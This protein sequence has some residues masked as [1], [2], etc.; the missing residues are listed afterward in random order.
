MA[1]D[2][3]VVEQLLQRNVIG[4]EST[5][6]EVQMFS[7]RR[8]PT[9]PRV[10]STDEWE[11]LATKIRKQVLTHVVYRG[12]AARWRDVET[13]V[14][15][16]DCIVG[17]PG[18]R[19]QKL[20]Y[21]ALPGMW[22]PALLYEPT[23]LEGKVPVVTNVNGHE[24]IGKAVD[25]KQIRC[26]NQAKRGMLALNVEWLG[27]GQLNAPGFTHYAMNQLD[28]CGTSGLAPF[29]LTLKR[30]LDVLLEHEH[31]DPKRVGVAGLSGGGCRRSSSARLILV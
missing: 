27:M 29:Y 22:I 31:A 1:L 15:W 18:Y 2:E 20:R 17:G 30:G 3:A 6:A 13:R 23:S 10:S 16:L 19:I 12:E 8:I 5:L 14:E 24:R 9:V 11:Q 26:I 25:Y 4:G 28:L 7:E 21:E